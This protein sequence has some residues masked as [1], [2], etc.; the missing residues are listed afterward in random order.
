[1]PVLGGAV[2]RPSCHAWNM[3]ASMLALA[4]GAPVVD[5]GCRPV[6]LDDGPPAPF[7]LLLFLPFLPPEEDGEDGG[8]E[9]GAGA[10]GAEVTRPK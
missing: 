10:G 5:V 6:L 9:G 7:F 8:A 4:G 2:A 3:P 1:M